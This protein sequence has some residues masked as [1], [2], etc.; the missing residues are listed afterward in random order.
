VGPFILRR[1]VSALPVLLLVS[2]AAFSLLWLIPGDAAVAI[3]GPDVDR[4]TVEALR[5][6]LGLDRSLP[7]QYGAWLGRAL[8][9][10]LGESLR[11]HR[12]IIAAVTER[13]PAT[14]ELS[15][16]AMFI[17]L[18]LGVP[19]GIA[20]A[21]RHRSWLDVAGSVLSLGGVSM[22]NFW[23]GILLILGFSVTLGW[24]P[25]SGYVPLRESVGQNLEL[26]LM[27]ALTLGL[28]LA[29]TVTR[30]TRA[31]VLQVLDLDY[32]RTARA[33]G[34]QEVRVIGVHVLKNALIPVV[35]IIGLQT[36]RLA[37]GA[38]ITETIF[39]IPGLGRLAVDSLLARDFPVIQA[40]VLLMA[41]AV[42]LSNL[43]VD[44]AYAYLDP[45]IRYG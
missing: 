43:L 10:D 28:A 23:L 13:L 19:L 44:I 2:F 7:V 1:I 15:A 26:M 29:A 16:L 40:V 3:L 4:G 25:P 32:V 22:P 31:S 33:K 34:A 24:L 5:R 35:T 18:A 27:P 39:G 36:G 30:Q 38:V 20:L 42:V 41:V 12:P 21:A 11:D 17:A 6:S 9:G 37:G 8:R 14:L 45:R